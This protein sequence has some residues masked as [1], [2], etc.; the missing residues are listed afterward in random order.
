[1]VK[2]TVRKLAGVLHQPLFRVRRQIEKRGQ[3]AGLGAVRVMRDASTGYIEGVILTDAEA[4]QLGVEAVT[5]QPFASEPVPKRSRVQT[6][7]TDADFEIL[8]K[9]E[10]TEP[11]EVGEAPVS[12]QKTGMVRKNVPEE[13]KKEHQGSAAGGYFFLGGIVALGLVMPALASRGKN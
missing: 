12:S 3:V 13:P 9:P 4:G 11:E 7:Q 2:L 6:S 5:S 10:D 1:M 8:S